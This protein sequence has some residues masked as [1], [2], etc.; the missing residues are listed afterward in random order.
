MNPMD[1]SRGAGVRL[2][3]RKLGLEVKWTRG[4]REEGLRVMTAV[5]RGLCFA[6]ME[7]CEGLAFPGRYVSGDVEHGTR[8]FCM[9]DIVFISGSMMRDLN[10]ICHVL[11][12]KHSEMCAASG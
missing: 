7:L 10:D 3:E 1:G 12:G 2:V 4:Y 5:E 8:H 11:H 6:R 9:C